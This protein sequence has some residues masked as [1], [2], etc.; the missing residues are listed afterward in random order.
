MYLGAGLTKMNNYINKECWK[1][2][3]DKYYKAA[4]ANF[5]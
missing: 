3:S 5:E 1:M 4:V 2:S